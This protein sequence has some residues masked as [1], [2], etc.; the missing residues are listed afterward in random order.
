MRFEEVLNEL[1]NLLLDA[2]RIPLTNKRV[3]EELELARIMDEL[4]D[5]LPEELEQAREILQQRQRILDEAQDEARHIV[6]QAKQ[7]VLRLTEENVIT[8]QAQEQA[9]E[10]VVQAQQMSEQLKKDSVQYAHDVF[11][12]LEEHLSKVTEVVREGHA[13]LKTTSLST[14]NHHESEQDAENRGA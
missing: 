11:R 1:E 10:I 7:Y 6:D 12:H 5:S 9:N 8:K 2:S 14:S 3:I 13:T 4:R